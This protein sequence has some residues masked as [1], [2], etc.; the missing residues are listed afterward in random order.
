M[1]ETMGLTGGSLTGAERLSRTHGG[2]DGRYTI[3]GAAIGEEVSGHVV[4]CGPLEEASL[5]AAA[6]PPHVQ[7]V[8]LT[9]EDGEAYTLRRGMMVV[10]GTPLE[11]ED[12]LRAGV[13]RA[14]KVHVILPKLHTFQS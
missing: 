5:F 13:R 7:V 10:Q 3:S 12:L 8:V 11:R 6:C 4:F 2:D 14:I 9:M 1:K